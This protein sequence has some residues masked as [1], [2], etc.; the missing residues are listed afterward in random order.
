MDRNATCAG[1]LWASKLEADVRGENLATKALQYF[2]AY[3]HKIFCF[4]DLQPYVGAMRPP[5]VQ[6]FLH[7]INAWLMERGLSLFQFVEGKVG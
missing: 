5:V 4:N 2:E 3:G 7:K 6:S 1:M